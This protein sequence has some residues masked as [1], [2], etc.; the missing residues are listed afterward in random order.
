M[1]KPNYVK[2][3]EIIGIHN[4]F[5]I[6]QE[7]KSGINIIYG[8]NGVGK[9]TLIHVLTNILNGDY[10]R[11]FDI[12]FYRIKVWYDNENLIKIYQVKDDI[13]N[14]TSEIQVCANNDRRGKIIYKNENKQEDNEEEDED[15]LEKYADRENIVLPSAYFP[16]FRNMIEAWKSIEDSTDIDNTTS[17]AR[18]VFGDFTPELNYPSIKDVQKHLVNE[19]E[20]IA[21]KIKDYDRSTIAQLSVKFLAKVNEAKE[22]KKTIKSITNKIKAIYKK[23]EGFPISSECYLSSTEVYTNILEMLDS[24]NLNTDSTI[25][26][27]IYYQA[28]ENILNLA[29][30]NFF[31]INK[32]LSAVNKFL[33]GKEIKIVKPN[34]LDYFSS[35]TVEFDDNS[36]V[37]TLDVLSSGERHIL[38]I[39]YTATYISQKKVVLIDEPEISLHIDWQRK[40]ISRISEQLSE[41]QIIACTHSPMITADHSRQELEL[42]LTDP[43]MWGVDEKDEDDILWS[44][45]NKEIDNFDEYDFVTVTDDEI[46]D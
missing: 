17:F 15:S 27:N 21:E 44:I 1:L 43:N 5:D 40:L 39:I 26:L 7:F 25:F 22:N 23:I 8:L 14:N 34:I 6:Y 31:I 18:K 28:L 45:K 12:K 42:K 16:A 38:T 4:R 29:T 46:D 30:E 13:T 20:I 10:Y 32:F 36:S 24:E 33:D 9:T 35:I 2:K 3:I 37:A 41:I 11:F 19:I